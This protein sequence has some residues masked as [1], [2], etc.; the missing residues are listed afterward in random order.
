MHA[1][2]RHRSSHGAR[3]FHARLQL[4]GGGTPRRHGQ[5]PL[6][7]PGRVVPAQ[8]VGVNPGKREMDA[9]QRRVAL[10]RLLVLAKRQFGL[11]L[12]EVFAPERLAQAGRPRIDRED[13]LVR[14]LRQTEVRLAEAIGVLGIRRREAR[15]GRGTASPGRARCRPARRR[16]PTA[17]GRPSRRAAG[18]PRVRARPR[19]PRPARGPE[20]CCPR[21]VVRDRTPDRA[22]RP[23]ETPRAPRRGDS[24]VD[25][26]C[27]GCDG[28][29]PGH[30]RGPARREMPPPPDPAARP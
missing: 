19:P 6:H 29:M 20:G 23:R 2:L 21:A 16:R 8:G 3:G 27:R 12:L 14:P 13:P 1:R 4:E 26:R 15:P 9:R 30:R 11:T 25:G 18:G 28:R 22:G 17:G 7:L 24:A 10:G 5:F